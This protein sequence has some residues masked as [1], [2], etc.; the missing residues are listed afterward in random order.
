MARYEG[1]DGVRQ[2]RNGSVVWAYEFQQTSKHDGLYL[3]QPP[4]KG[5]LGFIDC[6]GAD[7]NFSPLCRPRYFVPF[8]KGS[9]DD[10]AWSKAIA[11]HSRCYADTEEE[12]IQGYNDLVAREIAWHQDRIN[13]LEEY[14]I[15]VTEQQP[16]NGIQD[17][18]QEW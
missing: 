15:N 10:Y 11:L 18:E 16:R 2:L 7:N 4:I 12:A 3:N 1:Y 8:K 5:R 14:R 17:G 6:M 13:K 9:E